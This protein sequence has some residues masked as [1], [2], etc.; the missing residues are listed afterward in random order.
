MILFQQILHKGDVIVDAGSNIG[1]ISF[2]NTRADQAKGLCTLGIAQMCF[3]DVLDLLNRN[4]LTR[5]L[6]F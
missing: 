3:D 1:G 4:L 2:A 5:S 6:A